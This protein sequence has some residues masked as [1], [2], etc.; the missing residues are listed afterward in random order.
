VNAPLIIF[1][2]FIN[3][4]GQNR[5]LRRDVSEKVTKNIAVKYFSFSLKSGEWFVFLYL[6]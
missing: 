6:F 1:Y 5:K 4:L 2:A 3:V